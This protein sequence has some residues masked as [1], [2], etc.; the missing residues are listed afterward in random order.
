M[1]NLSHPANQWLCKIIV[2]VLDFFLSDEI[3]QSK[4]CQETTANCARVPSDYTVQ[5]IYTLSKKTKQNSPILGTPLLSKNSWD[6]DSRSL[7]SCWMGLGNWMLTRY[8]LCYVDFRAS[9]SHRGSVRLW[10]KV[11][12]D[13]A[14]SDSFLCNLKIVKNSK[15]VVRRTILL[16]SATALP[17]RVVPRLQQCVRGSNGKWHSHECLRPEVSQKNIVV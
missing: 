7:G 1:A 4:F 6:M 12:G 10:S 3:K 2:K 11:S 17:M 15:G 5:K 8:S 16:L 14:T 9:G 13:W